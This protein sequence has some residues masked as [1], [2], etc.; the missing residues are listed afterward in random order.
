MPRQRPQVDHP[1]LGGVQMNDN[2]PMLI[3]DNDTSS[4]ANHSARIAD[5]ERGLR[6]SVPRV[7]QS[8]RRTQEFAVG[9]ARGKM[10]AADVD[11]DRVVEFLNTAYSEG[12]L[13][14]DEYDTRLD[15]ALSA[16]TY[17]TR[18][19]RSPA[20]LPPGRPRCPR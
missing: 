13:S 7:I 20:C 14:K 19:S 9:G 2:G 16:R 4:F 11:R 18:P 6:T 8:A 17:A 10:R 5:H 1:K 3:P 15:N 12:R